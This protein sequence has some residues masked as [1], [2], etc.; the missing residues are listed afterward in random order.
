MDRL[1]GLIPR[2]SAGP[3]N[4]ADGCQRLMLIGAVLLLTLLGGC[5]S[6]SDAPVA[7]REDTGGLGPITSS[8]Y[9][10]RSGDTLWSI[11]WRAGLDYRQV[12]DWNRLPPPYTIYPGQWLRLTSPYS[13]ISVLPPGR[14]APVPTRSGPSLRR[15][16][17]APSQPASAA[18]RTASAMPQPPR[19]Q[20]PP[21]SAGSESVSPESQAASAEARS[22]D[23]EN[24]P[25]AEAADSVSEE[26]GSLS[27]QWPTQGRIT[28]GFA[29]GDAT[30][31]GVRIAGV[32]G[33]P[34]YA[35]ERGRVVYSGSGLIGYGQLIIIKHNNDFLS[36]Y[37]YNS[38]ILVKEGE[39]VTKGER[40]AEMGRN[41]G[42]APML[43]FEIRQHGKPIDPET[44]LPPR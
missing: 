19:S 22:G 41:G 32:L 31:K 25:A 26:T 37:G 12:S 39:Q 36:A 30:R 11:A 14:S 13:R 2:V 7:G 1:P 38:K 8:T 44:V 24:P 35:A 10:V 16:P 33:Q 20:P 9:R 3:G 23:V 4:S 28:Q 34:V 15:A 17:A 21:V 27:W 18:P 6:L 40:I 43:H 5:S 29:E 42:G